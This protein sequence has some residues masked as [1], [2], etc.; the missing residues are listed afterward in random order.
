MAL[1]GLG[2]GLEQLLASVQ[3]V[4]VPDERDHDLG[5]RVAAGLLDRDLG[6][7]D[8]PGLDLHEV[9]EHQAQATAAQAE[10]RV[11][12]VQRLDRREQLLVLLGRAAGCLGPGDLDEL[13][14]E[15]GQE[16]V[17]RRVEQADDDRQAVHRLEDALEV[18]LLEH[19]ELGHRRVEAVDGL[20]VVAR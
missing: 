19:L 3:L 8:R 5:D 2:L 12:L 14:L 13:L 6:V 9:R 4:G 16:L 11:L 18:A 15:V 10:H 17:Q 20:L 7:E 1:D